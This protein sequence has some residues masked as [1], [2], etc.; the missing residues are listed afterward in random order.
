MNVSFA[1]QAIVD[2]ATGDP[3]PPS[4][5]RRDVPYNL[6]ANVTDSD[7]SP[8]TWGTVQ[9]QQYLPGF[10]WINQ[11]TYDVKSGSVIMPHVGFNQVGVFDI[12]LHFQDNI[13]DVYSPPLQITVSE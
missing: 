7:G 5:L 12:R 9:L 2:S 10:G 13:D 8:M 3:I 4:Q 11:K 6:I 1:S